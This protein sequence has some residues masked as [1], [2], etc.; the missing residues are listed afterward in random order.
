VTII[1]SSTVELT[2][3]ESTLHEAFERLLDEGFGIIQA[4]DLVCSQAYDIDPAFYT[5][6]VTP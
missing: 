6:L 3:R 2:P 4:A 1:D 5:W